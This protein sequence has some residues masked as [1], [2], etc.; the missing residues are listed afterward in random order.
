M[1]GILGIVSLDERRPVEEQVVRRMAAFLEGRGD[2]STPALRVKR[3]WALGV[4]RY[5]HNPLCQRSEVGVNA[6]ESVY[7]VLHGE[8]YNY[9]ALKD[10][11]AARLRSEHNGDVNLLPHLY[12]AHGEAMAQGINGLFSIALWDEKEQKLLLMNDR[13]G[14]AHPIYWLQRDSRFVFAT[15]LRSLMALPDFEREIDFQALN[16]FFKYSYIPSP[17]TI[18]KGVWKM[19]PG[20]LIVFSKEGIRRTRHLDFRIP[21]ERISDEPS[22]SRTYSALLE[23]SIAARMVSDREVGVFLSGGLDTSANVALATRVAGKRIKTFT[24]G[25]DDPAFDERPSAQIVARHFNTEHFEYVITGREID[26]LPRL[27]WN[28]EEPYFE[29]GLFLTYLGLK[30]AKQ[31]VDIVIGGE[32]A[33][34]LFGTGGFVKAWPATLRYV[35]DRVHLRRVSQSIAN[36]M[37]GDLFYNRDNILFKTRLFLYR[38]NDLNDWYFYGYDARE[39]SDLYRDRALSEVPRIFD[40]RPPLPG[41]TYEDLYN[42]VLIHQDLLHYANE[43]VMVKSGRMANFL[44]MTLRESYLDRDVVDFLLT[45]DLQ[46]KRKGSVVDFL[47]GTSKAKYLHRIT[48]GDLLPGEIMNKPKQGG[49]VPLR[50]FMSD[51]SLRQRIYAH[52]SHSE[53]IKRHFRLDYLKAI[54]D[55]YEQAANRPTNWYNYYSSKVN[56]ILFL[57]VFDLWHK[58]FVENK[59]LSTPSP[60]LSDYL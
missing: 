51:P 42:S 12:E 44:G 57:L 33:D 45:L 23:K 47:R 28:L 6:A 38:V 8:I 11:L 10:A 9:D 14:L 15:H 29:L 41:P 17:R 40:N 24:I 35:L 16:L 39:L 37:K 48:V 22:A 1:E 18:F 55:T 56:R 3:S 30:A 19:S 21:E 5:C 58:L 59:T 52:L 27:I 31:E 7:A 53:L 25:F 49:F 46:L 32:G 4:S 60:R 26:D 36:R 43:N 34:Q 2:E 20:E 50:V 13:F 54:F